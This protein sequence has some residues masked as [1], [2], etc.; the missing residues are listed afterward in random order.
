MN[1]GKGNSIAKDGGG[2]ISN[3][4]VGQG[5]G[6]KTTRRSRVGG[7]VKGTGETDRGGDWSSSP[8]N[9]GEIGEV[10]T[11]GSDA[12]A[13]ESMDTSTADEP[14]K[15][16][17]S[18]D[19][20]G[21]ISLVTFFL[22]IYDVYIRLKLLF[23]GK[24]TTGGSGSPTFFK[25]P[26]ALIN[27][28][29][30]ESSISS[31]FATSAG[32]SSKISNNAVETSSAYQ[33]ASTTPLSNTS[34]SYILANQSTLL[35]NTTSVIYSTDTTLSRISDSINTTTTLTVNTK[36]WIFSNEISS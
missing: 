34:T 19:I 15:S 24:I 1:L 28:A 6:S 30:G 13:T 2:A 23:E 8:D 21:E 10:E 18:S 29:G 33:N 16:Q 4:K 31:S 14:S 27:N 26:P 3:G 7:A 36:I 17:H 5:V 25:N 12:S 20:N 32:V 11:G 35:P 9:K 22:S